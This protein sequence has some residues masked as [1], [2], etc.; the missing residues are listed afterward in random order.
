MQTA[1]SQLLK[2]W[3]RLRRYGTHTIVPCNLTYSML[4]ITP[5]LEEYS[6][7]MQGLAGHQPGRGTR[8]I[9]Y[10]RHPL[11]TKHLLL[12]YFFLSL[13]DRRWCLRMTSFRKDVIRMFKAKV[14]R[15]GSCPKPWNHSGA[16]SASVT[17]LLHL[18]AWARKN[19]A[20]IF[21][22]G[23]P[24]CDFRGLVK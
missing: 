21:D 9:G 19:V 5:T 11:M 12:H 6:G 10:L 4:V 23:R 14:A 13:Q 15:A 2:S 7:C 16:C 8:N 22:D 1:F 18:S 24:F 17:S 20:T 3:V